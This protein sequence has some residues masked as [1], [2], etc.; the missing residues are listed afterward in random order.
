MKWKRPLLFP[1]KHCRGLSCEGGSEASI[2]LESALILP[3]FMVF[4]LALLEIIRICCV[5]LAFQ[6]SVHESVKEIATHMYPAQLFIEQQL[7]QTGHKA[8]PLSWEQLKMDHHQPTTAEASSDSSY[9]ISSSI[10]DLFALNE[11]YKGKLQRQ[12]DDSLR[13]AVDAAVVPVIWLNADEAARK[14][15]LKQDNVHILQLMLPDFSNSEQALFGIEA[16]YAM[17]IS[18]PFYEKTIMFRSRAV[19]RGWIGKA[20]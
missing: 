7:D 14:R 2:T 17:H 16:E 9:W 8:A 11:R 19:E 10:S 20:G 15:W 6:T 3:L 12:W 1:I 18:L 5:F 4:V 13:K